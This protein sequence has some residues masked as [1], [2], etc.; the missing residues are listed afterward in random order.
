MVTNIIRKTIYHQ[1]I[2]SN[3]T[4]VYGYYF[5]KTNEI[6][7]CLSI[8]VQNA[9]GDNKINDNKRKCINK[10]IKCILINW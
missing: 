1:S 6:E 10:H 7:I 2:L 4:Q 8:F 5:T 3:E 9:E